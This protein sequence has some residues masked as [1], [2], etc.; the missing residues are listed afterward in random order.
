[1]EQKEARAEAVAR[2]QEA[3]NRWKARQAARG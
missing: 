3:K 2:Y 1:V